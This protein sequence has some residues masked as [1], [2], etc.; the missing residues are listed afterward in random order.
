MQLESEI[1]ELERRLDE[2]SGLVQGDD[3]DVDYSGEMDAVMNDVLVRLS[4]LVSHDDAPKYE[5][6]FKRMHGFVIS[7]GEELKLEQSKTSKKYKQ[8][9]ELL[10][11]QTKYASL[12]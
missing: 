8:Q 10:K 3:Q 11:N 12:A 4:R 5:K 6:K 1:L 9:S 7:I 2:L